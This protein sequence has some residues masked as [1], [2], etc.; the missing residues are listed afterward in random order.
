VVL[1]LIDLREQT[2]ELGRHGGQ[3][4]HSAALHHFY[5]LNQDAFWEMHDALFP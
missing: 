3:N 2:D 5:R 4:H 1:L